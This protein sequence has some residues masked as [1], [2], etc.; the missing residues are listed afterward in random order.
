MTQRS[1]LTRAR[2]APLVALTLLVLLP[3]GWIAEHLAWLDALVELLFA[4]EAAHALG[5]AVAFAAVGSA[6]LWIF[7][8]LLERP[9]GY[10]GLALLVALG[11]EGLQLITKGRGVVLNDL[12]D[13]GTDLVAAGLIFAL[14]RRAA[15]RGAGSDAVVE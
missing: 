6:L 9:W 13:I 15:R 5:H 10:L 7:P 14:A 2:L 11:Q 12:T 3:Y 4:T 1:S 8:G